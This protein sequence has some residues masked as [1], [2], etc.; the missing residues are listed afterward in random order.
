MLLQ[1]AVLARLL[2]PGD[3]GLMALVCAVI[4][5]AQIF[6]DMGISNAI[7]HHQKINQEVLSS[8]F[9]LNL[10]ASSLLMLLMMSLSPLIAE[11]YH[12][13]RM[14]AL[15]MLVSLSFLIVALGQQLRVLAE[16]NLRF[17]Q[18]A[19]IELTASL[20]GFVVSVSV[21]FAGG[22]VFALVA[23]M[24]SNFLIA[25]LLFWLILANG[26]RPL[27]RLRVGEIKD[28]LGFGA[29]MVGFSLTNTINLQADILI[30]GRVLGTNGLGAF[31]LPKDL[32][33]RLAM[34]INP[35]VTRVGLPVMAQA[36]GDKVL[37]K[38]IYLKTLRMTASVNFPL[39]FMIAFF[40]PEIVAIMFGAQWQESVPLLRILAL[41]GAVRSTGNPSGS[42][43]F[44]MGRSKLAFWWS[45]WLMLF[46][47]PAYW[48]GSQYGI[49]GL[50]LSMLISMMAVPLP[51]WFITI[52][53]LC[54]AG[55]VEY[56]KQFAIPFVISALASSGGFAF[57]TLFEL[58]VSRLSEWLIVEGFVIDRFIVGGLMHSVLRL[59]TGF[60]IGGLVYIVLSRWL[61]RSWFAAITEL[62][63]GKMRSSKLLVKT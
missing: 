18:L 12:E 47:I 15:L 38:S 22:G 60:L 10:L 36:Q 55:F 8:L 41:W 28:F 45:F 33:L 11:L 57:A 40:A 19:I 20:I 30:G 49:K 39:Y 58:I 25:T 9:W 3:F 61:N 27:W 4:A 16:K 7:I 54:G 21:A 5:F 44:A 6:S 13:P 14:Q 24:L 62:L 42:L 26:W 23:G 50:A 35:I 46:L 51:Q 1:M 31:S 32:S 2:T 37:L 53:P 56:F 43:I 48:I 59:S 52:R 29:Y 17:Q 34:I 63:L